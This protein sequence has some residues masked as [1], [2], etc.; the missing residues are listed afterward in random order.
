M[1]LGELRVLG[2]Q[3]AQFR[4]ERLHFTQEF[5]A[6]AEQFLRFLVLGM[7]GLAHTQDGAPMSIS[8]RSSAGPESRARQTMV[9]VGSRRSNARDTQPKIG[10]TLPR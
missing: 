3:A 2:G 9:V 1:A 6:C 10:A 5:P 4:A 7:F 8:V